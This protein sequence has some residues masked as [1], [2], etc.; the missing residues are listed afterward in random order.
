MS[1]SWSPLWVENLR[2]NEMNGFSV[3]I[4]EFG[5]VRADSAETKGGRHQQ[6]TQL[7][8]GNILL[9]FLTAFTGL[10]SEKE[11]DSLWARSLWRADV[12]A[13]NVRLL[14]LL[15][16]RVHPGLSRWNNAHQIHHWRRLQQMILH[17]YW[18]AFQ[19]FRRLEPGTSISNRGNTS[20]KERGMH[21]L[22]IK[23]IFSESDG[24]VPEWA[25]ENLTQNGKTRDNCIPC[26]VWILQWATWIARWIGS[27]TSMAAAQLDR[28]G[29]NWRR[30][31]VGSRSFFSMQIKT[32]SSWVF[33]TTTLSLP[34]W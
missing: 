5:G 21:I 12:P 26:S 8:N 7:R 13:D 3:K 9:W 6:S 31:Y 29:S 32:I 23:W 4:D 2:L 25:Q 33:F 20:C 11:E 17:N 19:E 15:Y 28:P 30:K 18:N 14:G 16:Q 27:S 24:E 10:I 34:H 1:G 22:L